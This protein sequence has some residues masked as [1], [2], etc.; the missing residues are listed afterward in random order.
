MVYTHTP[1]I[2]SSCAGS[3]QPLPTVEQTRLFTTLVWLLNAMQMWTSTLLQAAVA[4]DMQLAHPAEWADAAWK[5]ANAASPRQAQIELERDPNNPD[6]SLAAGLALLA[7][8]RARA[9][10]GRASKYASNLSEWKERSSEWKAAEQAGDDTDGLKTPG[11][12]PEQD[13][14]AE[15][16]EWSHHTAGTPPGQSSN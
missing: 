5:A 4:P 12:A 1:L 7:H 14:H 6:K 2:L 13:F 11:A 9:T 16:M 3:T 8:E 15:D 10:A